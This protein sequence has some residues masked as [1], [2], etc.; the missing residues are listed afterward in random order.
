MCRCQ[1]LLRYPAYQMSFHEWAFFMHNIKSCTAQHTQIYLLQSS[2]PTEAFIRTMW[3]MAV[4]STLEA[5]CIQKTNRRWHLTSVSFKTNITAL[6][7]YVCMHQSS[8]TWHPCL[9]CNVML[10]RWSVVFGEIEIIT[11]LTCMKK[12]YTIWAISRWALKISVD[13]IWPK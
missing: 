13:S 11:I 3:F 7:A 2:L 10:W 1:I 8:C 9:S 5:L 12:I 4:I 6:W